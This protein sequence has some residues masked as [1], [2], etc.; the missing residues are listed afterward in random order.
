MAALVQYAPP[1]LK[2]VKSPNEHKRGKEN[3][4]ERVVSVR[5]NYNIQVHEIPNRRCLSEQELNDLYL[6]KTEQKQIVKEIITTVRDFRLQQDVDGSDSPTHEALRGL[7]AFTRQ[8]ADRVQRL[9]KAISV[10]LRRQRI[11]PIDEIWLLTDYRPFSEAATKL[12]G[13]RGLRD[14]EL[15]P[16]SVPRRI[17]MAR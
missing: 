11:A 15:V 16:S 12:A 17:V 7:E 4:N 8:D 14:Q 3:N 2:Q 5:F 1:A 10:V 6:N 9:R 13:N